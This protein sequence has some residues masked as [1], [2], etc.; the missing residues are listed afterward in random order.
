MDYEDYEEEIKKIKKKN[1]KYISE[2]TKW[3]KEKKL[4]D[5]TINKHLSNVSFYIDVFLNYY[6]PQKMEAGCYCLNE[7][8][9]DFFIRKCMWSNANSTK[10]TAASLKKFY[11]CMYELGH[12]N[13]DD[14]DYLC[15]EIKENM[16]DWQE[17][18]EAYNNGDFENFYP[19]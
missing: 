2:F 6:E 18:V 7:Y 12:I 11:Q 10:S 9:S 8:F 13:K 1:K 15:D 5:K 14:Y 16:E 19:W 3:L 4:T 17:Q